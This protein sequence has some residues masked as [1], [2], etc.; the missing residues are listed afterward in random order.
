MAPATWASLAEAAGVSLN[1][2]WGPGLCGPGTYCCHCTAVATRSESSYWMGTRISQKSS[3]T[4]GPVVGGLNF[5]SRAVLIERLAKLRRMSSI[6]RSG[7]KTRRLTRSA[8]TSSTL[9][10]RPTLTS[11]YTVPSAPR[12]NM[13]FG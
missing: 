6:C 2:S 1:H 3:S 7:A 12:R 8:T 9:P 13:S 10:S 5:H 11:R 4:C